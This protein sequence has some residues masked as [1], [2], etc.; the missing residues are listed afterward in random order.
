MIPSLDAYLINKLKYNQDIVRLPE[1]GCA[2]GISGIIMPKT[3]YSLIRQTRAA[4]TVERSSSDIS[5]RS[6]AR[7]KRT[8]TRTKL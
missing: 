7:K 8:K 2:A 1:M 6:G 5:M 3:S 4:G